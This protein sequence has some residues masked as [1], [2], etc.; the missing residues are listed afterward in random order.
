MSKIINV[1]ALSGGGYRGLFTAQVLDQLEQSTGRKITDQFDLIAGTSI[2]G[3]IALGLADGRRP[4][5]IVEIFR[6]NGGVIFNSPDNKFMYYLRSMFKASFSTLYKNDGLTVVLKELFGEKQL[7]DLK[8]AFAIIPAARA[9]TGKPKFFKTPHN[10]DF[11]TD[12]N[13]PVVDVG[14]ATS[15]APVYFPMHYVEADNTRYLDGGLVGNAPGLFGYIEA[16]TRLNAEPENVRVLSIGTLSGKPCVSEKTT[17]SPRL[18]YWLNPLNPRLLDLVF[19]IQEHQT[20]NMLKILLQE[21]YAQI[22]TTVSLEA[23]KDIG[24]DK[25]DKAAQT[26]LLSRA[27][28]EAANFVNTKF[29]KKYLMNNE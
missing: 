18:N 12:L 23:S 10:D 29:Y 5:E 4:S 27:N 17:P 13:I 28:E 21:R 3:I 24:L 2:G 19:S 20:H 8:H 9:S 11:Y 14:L 16:I 26:A 25:K 7:K 22:D 15:A 6:K 1:L